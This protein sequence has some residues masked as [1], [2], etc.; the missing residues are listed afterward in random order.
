MKDKKDKLFKKDFS[1]M[2]TG[3]IISLF[4]NTI[5]RFALS[6]IVLD[7]TGS[8]A[9]FGTILALSMIP[10]ILLSAL[11]GILAD[12][13]NKRSIMVALDFTTA[14]CI[15]LFAI[16]FHSNNSIIAIAILMVV[17][18]IIQAFYQPSVQ[19]SIPLLVDETN[20]MVANGTVIQVNALA[21]LLG[22]IVGGL[23][24]GF[25]GIYPIVYASIL[26]F[27]A[28]AFMECFIYIPNLKHNHQM[29]ILKT[30]QFDFKESIHF[31]LHQQ[32]DLLKL[33]LLIAGINLF[34][35]AMIIVGLPYLIKILLGLSN[36]LYGLAEGVMGIGSIM[37]GILAGLI[38]K[39]IAF[40]QSY[41]FLIGSG[42]AI[43]P[44]GIGVFLS[45]SPMLA[46]G[47]ILLGILITML[48]ST[49]FSIY[50]QTVIQKLTPPTMLGKIS[51]VVTV[52]CMCSLPI[53]QAIYG[54]IFDL[55]KS[56]SFFIVFAVSLISLL[57]GFTSKTIIQNMKL[58]SISEK[59]KK[60]IR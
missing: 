16:V 34:L 53:G 33:L 3:Q 12:R 42:I 13:I 51:S 60:H 50:G 41:W 4:G 5:L 15:V 30:I 43:L 22:P 29:S 52:I 24:Y 21:N 40:Q 26:C 38:S 19:S 44:I 37:G 54:G 57:I 45:S 6:M 32:K 2:I 25:L 14:I 58:E 11:G 28:C 7:S 46:Y 36:P 49:L 9:I 8:V 56:N 27:F 35:S 55:A 1:L 20:L 47:L 31:L 59:E 10:T 23:L 18:S 39:K 17:L 48:L